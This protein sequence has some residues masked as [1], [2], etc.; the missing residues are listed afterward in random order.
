MSPT[1]KGILLAVLA[2]LLWGIDPLFAQRALQRGTAAQVVFWTLVVASTLL[3]LAHAALM[4]LGPI[5][6]VSTPTLTAFVLAGG[7]NYL[8][9]RNFYFSSIRDVGPARSVPISSTYPL[10]ASAFAV[11]GLGEILTLRR[12]LGVLLVVA[13]IL[14]ITT[15]RARR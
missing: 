12:A 3:L 5:W 1:G 11:M 7:T 14:C 9:G 8:L 6:A 4:G 2:A 13:G 10:F 15:E